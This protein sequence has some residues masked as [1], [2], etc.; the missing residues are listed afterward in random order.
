MKILIDART[1]GK[2]PSGVGMYLYNFICGLMQY[3]TMKMELLTDVVESA[4]MKELDEAHIP[5]HRYGT[6]V[7][8]SIGVYAYF[9]FVQN[10]INE[11]KPDL[12]WEVNNLTPVV[13]RNPYGKTAVTVHDVFPITAP[14]G[15]GRLYPHYF[16][17]NLGKTLRHMDAVI[18]NSLDTKTQVEQYY[19][20]AKALPSCISYIITEEMPELSI[21]DEGYF[22]YIGNLE[23][24]KGTDLLLKAYVHYRK[25]GGT[26]KLYLAGK[27]RSD[28]IE[29]LLGECQKETDGVC[30]QGYLE[31]EEK[32][33]MYAA[34]SAFLFPS[35]AEGFGMPVIEALTYRKPVL[36]SDLPIF[37]E[38]AGDAVRYCKLDTEDAVPQ[39]AAAMRQIGEAGKESV[40]DSLCEAVAGRYKKER[41]AGGLKEFLETIGKK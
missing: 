9:R 7:E 33:R 15:Y 3:D 12:F 8:K 13:I 22:L 27:I 25:D 26:K 37:H 16:K 28:M 41:L 1:L 20:A 24:R 17:W 35:R 30:Y 21:R 39:L 34:C 36:V 32:Y 18:Y 40:P 11:V 6:P 2:R 29:T 5:I 31:T 14:Y 19:P 10:K 23:E 4:A 38:I